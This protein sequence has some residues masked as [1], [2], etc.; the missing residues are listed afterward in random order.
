V[1]ASERALDVFNTD[2]LQKDLRQ[3]SVRGGLTTIGGQGCQFVL[4]SVSTVVLAHLLTPGDFG[5]VAMVTA[6]TGVAQAFADLGLSEATIQ[7]PEINHEQISKLFWINVGIGLL[8]T[9]VTA[10]MAPIFVRFYHQASL[11]QITYAV[12][13]SFLIGGLRVQHDA[14]LKRQM[15]FTALAFRDV[16]SYAIAVPVAIILAWK[17]AG[18]WA[19]VA[20]P[21]TLNTTAM[22]MS[23]ILVPWMPGLPR[24]ST[25][26]R[27]LITFGGSVAVSYLVFSFMRTADNVLIGWYWG[28]GPLGLYSRAFNLLILPVRQLG[29]PTR[30]V[31]IPAFSRL[32]DDRERLARF[33]LRTA[34]LIMW[35]TAPIF[36]FLFVAARPVIVLALGAKWRAA[37]P[38]FQLLAIYA[39]GYL[40]F[41]A[42]V[43]LI[44]SRGESGRL[45]KLAMIFSPVTVLS[46]ALGLPFGIKGVALCGATV[47]LAMLPWALK[48]SFHG[49][50]LT[51]RGVGRSV[52][53]PVVTSLT[54][55]GAAE[56]VLH[57]V[58]QSNAVAEL[59]VTALAFAA[60]S[61]LTLLIPAI[62]RE[63]GGLGGLLRNAR[64]MGS[65][66]MI[67]AVS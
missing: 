45:F 20:L 22:V 62:R 9:C 35:M 29:P 52:I 59:T 63:L 12:S 54:G 44:V 1:A 49:T 61:A 19:I 53:L 66:P 47:S 50:A 24:R 38:V 33:F 48:F 65:D 8:L 14:L 6:I 37:V 16:I 10:A 21:L 11:R 28:A 5:L 64:S 31:A 60:G 42:M 27:S 67:E 18:Y 43:W 46:F 26:I 17:G 2:H 3:R 25:E 39:L 36:G 15:R 55:L 40:L 56:I 32:Q 7:H 51:L 13:L 4:Q 58:P 23:W 57:V 41:E 34:N 30:S